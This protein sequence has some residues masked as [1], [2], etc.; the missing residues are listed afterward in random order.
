MHI[1][2]IHRVYHDVFKVVEKNDIG[3]PLGP[4]SMTSIMYK[5]QEQKKALES[6]DSSISKLPQ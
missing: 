5:A 4:K 2:D 3:I 1:E 6:F